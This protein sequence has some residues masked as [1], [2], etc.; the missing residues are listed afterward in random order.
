M[1]SAPRPFVSRS[2]FFIK[3]T[4]RAATVTMHKSHYTHGEQEN[5]QKEPYLRS[6]WQVVYYKLILFF[7]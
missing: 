6:K 4:K 3:L 2:N 1:A 5:D 7:F